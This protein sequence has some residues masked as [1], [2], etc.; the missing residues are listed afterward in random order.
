[1]IGF[2]SACLLGPIAGERDTFPSYRTCSRLNRVEKQGS[3]SW[4]RKTD[5]ND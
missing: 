3:S 4:S 1:M 2:S 5:A